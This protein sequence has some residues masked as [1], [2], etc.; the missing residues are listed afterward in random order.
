MPA[1]F[2]GPTR[3]AR[4]RTP[5][6]PWAGGEGAIAAETPL[7]PRRGARLRAWWRANALG[8]AVTSAVL[9]LVGIILGS[10]IE[11]YPALSDDEGTYVA[12]A[13]ALLT[14]GSLSHYTYWYDHP[15]LGW[16]QL[17]VA[18]W[19]LDPI[20]GGS[21][22]VAEA[23]NLMLIPALVSCALLFVLARRLGMNRGFAAAAVLLF[24]LS[25]LAISS[26]RAVYLDNIATPWIL[27]AFVLAASPQRRLWA[28]AASGA[29]FAVAVLT[30]ETSLLIL[31]GLIL[32]VSQTVDQRTRAFCM[33]AF[34]TILALV[35]LGYPLYALLK[36]ELL[37]GEGHVSLLEA[38][39]FQLYGRASTG[40]P[41]DPDSLSNQ[42]VSGW[43]DADPWLLALGVLL[44]PAALLVRRLRPVAVTLLVLVLVALRPG[45]LPQPFV[46]AMLP[47]CALVAAGLLDALWRNATARH[48]QR[49]AIAAVAVSLALWIFPAWREGAEHAMTDDQVAPVLEAERW[50]ERNVDHRARV[51]VDDTL[52]VDLVE[53]GFEPQFGAVWFYK[54]DFTTNLDPSIA[55]NL[56][57]GWRA[58]DY[59]VTTPV[60]RSALANNPGGLAQVRLALENSRTVAAFG[61][62]ERLVE[63]RR[64]TGVGTGSGRIPAA[65]EPRPQRSTRPE[66]RPRG[67]GP[68]RHQDRGRSS[69]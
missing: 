18:G 1:R 51:L 52:Y 25:P 60:I 44:A 3:R 9:A 53:A 24:A 26:L 43:L 66:D 11:H 33:T 45:Y 15:P 2:P 69:R 5:R 8:L 37:P 20:I 65:T 59:V 42:L 38:I 19:L 49:P 47:F 29:C 50:V 4:V 57:G 55:R 41:L 40:T 61:Y 28:Y 56:P 30:K 48:W 13:W 35:A 54:L 17:A 14:D 58:F 34:G 36:G 23:R 6:A 39:Q 31:P 12:E 7:L 64:I 22:A 63:V 46:I 68:P 67:A 10:G 21:S 62:G 16:I 27:A 32:M